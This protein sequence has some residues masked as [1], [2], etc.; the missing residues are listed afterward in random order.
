MG[1]SAEEQPS[2]SVLAGLVETMVENDVNVLYTDPVYASEYADSLRVMVE[3]QTGGS[4]EILPLYL[5]TGPMDGLDYFDQQ[6]AN[7]EN[8]KAGL[9]G[10]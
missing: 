4:V 9:V 3:Q 10:T 5:M 7:L 2:A 1:I 6:E 8:L